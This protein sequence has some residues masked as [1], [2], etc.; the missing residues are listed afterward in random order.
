VTSRIERVDR[1]GVPLDES[2]SDWRL[3]KQQKHLV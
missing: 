1:R 2:P 3:Y